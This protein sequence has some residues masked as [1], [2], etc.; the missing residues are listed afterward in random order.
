MI[1]MKTYKY[2]LSVILFI[3]AVISCTQDEF[4]S[5]DFVD[6]AVAPTNVTALF[7][8]TQDNTGTVTIAPNSEGAVSYDVYPGDATTEMVKVAQG[9][10]FKHVYAE[11][12]YNVKIVATGITGL[13][14]E[15]TLPLVVSFKAPENLVAEIL[16]DKAIS[17]KVNVTVTADYATS[18][19]VYFGEEGNDEPVPA[20]IG[21]TASYVYQEAGIY[22]IRVVAKSAAIQTTE[23]TEEFEVTAILQPI[24]SAVTP[25]K[26]AEIDVVSIF[27]DAYDDIAISEWNPNWGGQST[28]LSPFDLNGD[29]MLKYDFFSYTGIVTSY[30]NP[31]D[32]STME[33][34]HFDYWTNDA[35]QIGFKIVNTSQADGPLKE[36]E[37][38]TPVTESGKWVSVDIPLTD[39]TTDMSGVTQLVL[40]STGVTVF[41]DNIYFWKISDE[42]FDGGLVI[43]G[44]FENGAEPWTEG[45]DDTKPAPIVTEGDN[46]YYS[47]NVATAGAAYTV[48]VSQK[49]EII[50]GETYTLSFDAWSDRDRPILPGIGLSANPWTNVTEGVNITTTKQTYTLTFI[51]NAGAS[52]A[53]VF[54]DLGAAVGSV[55][56]DNVS[57]FLG[58]GTFDGGLVINGDFE[59]GAEPWTIGVGTDPVP[60]VT[61]GGNTYYSVNVATAGQPFEVNASQKLEIIEGET[62]TLSFDAWSDRDRPILPGIGLSADPWTNKT[63]EVNITTTKQTYT[64]TLIANAGASDARVFFDLGAAVGSVNLDNV[65]LFIVN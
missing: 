64:V 49:L 44:D 60:V 25:P 29:N 4:G 41:M 24:K 31:T 27:S 7:S 1:I 14:T 26:R 40:S 38:I 63:E 48:N 35:T 55:N 2:I 52:D 19:E 43:N 34:V 62:Y 3:T 20:N 23:Y 32:L 50:E 33:Y 46:T 58:D 15:S 61:D 10:S 22:T 18:F 54:F 13:M 12:N 8:V 45:V 30:D 16:N 17:K 6:T 28:V 53:R 56:I 57:L 42:P 9:K 37:I 21:E 5:L 59:S 47:V 36:S 51:A 39:F 11:G 65:S